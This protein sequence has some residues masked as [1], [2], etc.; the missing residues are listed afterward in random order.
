MSRQQR[1][2]HDFYAINER[3]LFSESADLQTRAETPDPRAVGCSWS[4]GLLYV[5]QCSLHMSLRCVDIVPANPPGRIVQVICTVVAGL[6]WMP[7]S[8]NGCIDDHNN[9]HQTGK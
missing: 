4:C 7:F 2:Q 9:L 3:T 1:Y 8:L 6:R 5:S